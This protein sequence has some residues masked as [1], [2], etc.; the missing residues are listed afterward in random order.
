MT[1]LDRYLLREIFRYFFMVLI[2]VVAIYLAVDFFEKI[3]NFM[4]SG[5]PFSRTIDFF[6]YSIPFVLSQIIPVG[7]LLSVL[8]SFGIMNKHNELTALR[9]CGISI[10]S[11]LKPILTIGFLFSFVLFFLSEAVV[12]ITMVTANR[13]WLNEVRK[14]QA[15]STRENNI[16]MKTPNG[17]IHIRH[18]NAA[19]KT[20]YKVTLNT[21]DDRFRLIRRLD[22]ERGVF[23]KGQW[24]LYEI[25][26]QKLDESDTSYTIAFHDAMPVELDMNPERL[27]QVVKKT[28][29]MGI[30]E[31]ADYI[32]IIEDEG[33]SATQYRVDFHAKISFPFVCIILVLAGVGIACKNR[34]KDGLP[35][36]IAY[37]IG[38]AFLYWVL[39]SFCISLG[40]GDMLPPMIAAWATN[41]VFL[42]FGI[43]MLMHAEQI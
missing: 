31:L 13:I 6:L 22:A 39:N 29:E 16:W 2:L 3:D 33:Y 8:I 23:S 43:V 32:D 10:H 27:K 4:E 41:A 36:S 26:E 15:I 38:L 7:V 20:L 28:S 30:E 12:P 17:I 25:L 37:G 19:E 21:F 40:Y 9:S 18:Y 14:E 24:M 1:I 5:L 42:C 34:L 35:A 11:L